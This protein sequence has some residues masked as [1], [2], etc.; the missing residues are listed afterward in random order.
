MK[1]ILFIIALALIIST[2]VIAGTLSIYTIKLDDLAE[3]SVVAKEFVL[4]EGRVYTFGEDVKIGPGETVKWKFS[5][6]NYKGRIVSDTAM[7]LNF[8]VRIKNAPGK[9]AIEP[10]RITVQ[11]E[12]HEVM[13]SKTGTGT[14]RF[15]DKFKLRETGQE[16]VYTV[17][18]KWPSDDE[19]DINYSGEDFGTAVRVSVVGI[20]R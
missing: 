4:E 5:L 17:V 19:I 18:I 7:D 9:S 14:I 10:L 15:T 12:D 8:N 13:G 20:Q 11:D 6:K 3:G 2:S 16:K 1:R